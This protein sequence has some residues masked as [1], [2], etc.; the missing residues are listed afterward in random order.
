MLLKGCCTCPTVSVCG[1]LLWLLYSERQRIVLLPQRISV[2]QLAGFQR[3]QPLHH[4][5][6]TVNLQVKL[7]QTTSMS[8]CD[9]HGAPPQSPQANHSP[10][11]LFVK[12]AEEGN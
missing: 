9:L 4:A 2:A 7:T 3:G 12:A 6:I 8:V 1:Q 11:T 10:P 5:V